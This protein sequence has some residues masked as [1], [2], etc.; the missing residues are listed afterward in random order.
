MKKVA[1]VGILVADVIVSTV[2]TIPKK[3]TLENVNSI[4]LHNGGNAMTAA[5]NLKKLG[6]DSSIVG[7]VGSDSFG[8]FLEKKLKE[9]G[10]CTKGLKYSSDAQTSTSV[11]MIDENGERTFFHVIGANGKVTYENIDFN[12]INGCDAVF[13]TGTFL[14][15]GLDGE[16]TAKLLKK[17]REAGKKTFLDVQW[18]SSGRWMETLGYAMPYID[19]FM[20]SIDEARQLSKKDTPEEM[21]DVF[22]NKGVGAVVIKMGGD[23]CFYKEAGKKPCFISA[24]K[25]IKVV[26]TT[27]AGDSFCSG[28]LAAYSHGRDFAFCAEFAN[29]AGALS[30][31]KKGATSG[32]T[33]Y[34]DVENFMKT[35]EEEADVSNT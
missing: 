7:M 13:L 34:S 22:L 1:C 18:D 14:L 27:G 32:I 15:P 5:I 2:S 25:N 6:C 17:C 28:F 16:P 29:A 9:S 26:D 12:V 19:V 30:V 11:L 24:Y 21:A 31:T 4:S 23:G 8:E 20:P 3:G 33:T 10:V 35:K